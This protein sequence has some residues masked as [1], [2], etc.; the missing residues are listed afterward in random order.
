MKYCF[1]SEAPQTLLVHIMITTEE[2]TGAIDKLE[3]ATLNATNKKK[4]KEVYEMRYGYNF[5]GESSL[6]F[7]Q[8]KLNTAVL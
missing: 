5:G 7:P 1:L 8:C 4:L 3:K 6:M 2:N